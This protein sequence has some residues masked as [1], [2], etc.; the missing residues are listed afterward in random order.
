[1]CAV[2]FDLT[3]FALDAQL[4]EWR[5]IFPQEFT[6]QGFPLWK[7]RLFLLP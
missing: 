2:E 4:D 5:G 7:I 6:K 3:L 1:M